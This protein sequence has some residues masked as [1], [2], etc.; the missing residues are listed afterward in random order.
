MW[1]PV[2]GICAGHLLSYMRPQVG[3]QIGHIFMELEVLQTSCFKH[4]IYLLLLLLLFLVVCLLCRFL[5]LFD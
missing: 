3:S 2:R 1:A 4:L 5:S